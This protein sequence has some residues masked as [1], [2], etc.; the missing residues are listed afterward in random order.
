MH[1]TSMHNDS[2][3]SDNQV[4]KNIDHNDSNESENQVPKNIDVDD[5]SDAGDNVLHKSSMHIAAEYVC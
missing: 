4:P 5:D 3:E 1:S 2:N